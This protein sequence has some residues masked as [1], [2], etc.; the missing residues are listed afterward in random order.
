MQMGSQ[1]AA[2]ILRGLRG[3]AL[4]PFRYWDRGTFAVIGRGAAVGVAF[5]RFQLSGFLAWL[6]WLLI[7]I[8]FLVGFRSRLVVM[9]NWAY[10]YFTSRRGVR[11]ITGELPRPL[12]PRPAPGLPVPEGSG[13]LPGSP[14]PVPVPPR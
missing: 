1:T 14:P 10:A 5:R 11:L 4:K 7:H 9:I 2:N 12:L 13:V 6:A 3:E 8:L